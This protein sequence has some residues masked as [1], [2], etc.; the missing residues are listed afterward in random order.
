MIK[1]IIQNEQINFGNLYSF[2]SIVVK[3]YIRIIL[4][5]VLIYIIYFF[6]IKDTKYR[7][8]VSFYT[9]Y[10]EVSSASLSVLQSIQG[11]ET[12][13]L[14]FSISNFLNS[15]KFLDS[16]ILHEYSIGEGK[17]TLI[18][19]YGLS[20]NIS[21]FRP[22]SILRSFSLIPQLS[23]EEK[24][25][26]FSKQML[27]NS[28]SYYEDRKT[29]LNKISF[30]S[31]MSPD[32][33]KQ[34][35][36]KIFSSILDYSSE[37]TAVKAREKVSFIEGRVK[38]MSSKLESSENE[39]LLFLEKNKNL[40]SPHLQLKKDRIQRDINLYSQ[41]FRTLSDQLELAKIDEMDNTSSIIILDNSDYSP[42]KAGR[43][44]LENIFLLFCGLYIIFFTIEL[45]LN[46]KFIINK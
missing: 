6:G 33:T 23:L 30:I 8:S 4:F 40:N 14:S 15:N 44:V 12:G 11:N 19:L 1:P 46:R 16:V 7:A 27:S 22:K 10:N 35:V 20:A 38:D 31:T 24:K 18:D 13:D 43:T 25:L 37:V 34:V 36:E 45:Y 3:K 32:I 26:L 21:F 5:F 29:G 2:I 41:V 28:I 9:D 39:M 42:Y 17:K